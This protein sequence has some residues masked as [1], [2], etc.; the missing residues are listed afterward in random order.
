MPKSPHWGDLGGPGAVFGLPSSA[1]PALVAQ[2]NLLS[3]MK[4][5]AASC[6]HLQIKPLPLYLLTR[7]RKKRVGLCWVTGYE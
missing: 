7:P 4:L 5:F 6:K 3:P 2:A 1:S